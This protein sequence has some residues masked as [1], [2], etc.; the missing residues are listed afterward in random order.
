MQTVFVAVA[1]AIDRWE[2][3]DGST[4]FRNWLMRIAKNTT[5]NAISRRPPDQALAGS[6]AG[7]ALRELKIKF[8][9][10]S[11]N[12]IVNVRV[13]VPRKTNLNV[14]TYR[15]G[16]VRFRDIA[17]KVRTR[18]QH[19]DIS[20]Q[21]IAGTASA[22]S[23]NG[24]LKADFQSV[25][26]DARLDFETYNGNI[27]IALP[28]NLNA[29]MDVRAGIGEYGSDFD[30]VPT[31]SPT[32]AEFAKLQKKDGSRKYQFATINGGGVTV[33][34]ESRKGDVAIRKRM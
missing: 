22:Y 11:Q 19:C 7:A 8:D 20:L 25:S 18:S 27:D 23:Y 21:N 33:R 28:R 1:G 17:G 15:D 32:D 12:Y 30:L 26:K 5:I 10:D 3:R 16:Y 9:V 14:E 13:R 2:K 4:R 24:N 34:L 31:D 6:S 29:T